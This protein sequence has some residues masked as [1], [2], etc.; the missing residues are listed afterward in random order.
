TPDIETAHPTAAPNAA[1]PACRGTSRK[2]PGTIVEM[3]PT[4][5]KNIG[6]G[7]STR[8]AAHTHVAIPAVRPMENTAAHGPRAEAREPMATASTKPSPTRARAAER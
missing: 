2:P 8:Q 3:V 4:S 5:T 1:T 6:P 7:L